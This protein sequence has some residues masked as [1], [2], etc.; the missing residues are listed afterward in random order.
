M[1]SVLQD[2]NVSHGDVQHF[3]T[4][5]QPALLKIPSPHIICPLHP[6]GIHSMRL[7]L[8]LLHVTSVDDWPF[9]IHIS[10]ARSFSGIFTLISISRVSGPQ[11][12]MTFLIRFPICLTQNRI[13]THHY[14]QEWWKKR[15]GY[16]WIGKLSFKGFANWI[17][18]PLSLLVNT[19]G[20]DILDCTA[21][22][23]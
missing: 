3:I 21:P 16:W 20:P 6:S 22:Q 4:F 5:L 8:T 12:R 14:Q 17:M 18:L 9:Q 7:I 19:A 13:S 10:T 2:V 23:S 1:K 11:P 15:S